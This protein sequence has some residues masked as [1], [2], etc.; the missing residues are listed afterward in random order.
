MLKRRQRDRTVYAVMSLVRLAISLRLSKSL[1]RRGVL[2]RES[3]KNAVK[4]SA[5]MLSLSYFS[6]SVLGG[7]VFLSSRDLNMGLSGP[8]E[9]FS[10]LNPVNSFNTLTFLR[11]VMWPRAAVD[12]LISSLTG[13]RLNADIFLAGEAQERCEGERERACEW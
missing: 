12:P 13:D 8:E 1:P 11:W 4:H 10:S 3:V 6:V 9:I 7:T 2:V 5:V